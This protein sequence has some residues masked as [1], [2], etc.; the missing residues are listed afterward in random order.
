M[1]F[2]K[3][4]FGKK[5]EVSEAIEEYKPKEIEEK[6]NKQIGMTKQEVMN[7][8]LAGG[9]DCDNCISAKKC[10]KIRRKMKK[11]GFLR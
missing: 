6:M 3:R 9:A 2:W 10:M 1:S 4:I 5:Y 8:I 11:A 7:C